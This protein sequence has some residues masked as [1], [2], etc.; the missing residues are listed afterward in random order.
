MWLTDAE[1]ATAFVPASLVDDIIGAARGL[2][3]IYLVRK[4]GYEYGALLDLEAA[5]L[6]F[7]AADAL[8][9]DAE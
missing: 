2:T 3:D 9:A 1:F 5:L 8:I 6:A 7:D 4:E